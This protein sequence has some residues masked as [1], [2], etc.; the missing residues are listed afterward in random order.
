MA[1]F[2]EFKYIQLSRVFLFTSM[3]TFFRKYSRVL[4]GLLRFRKLRQ[5][6]GPQCV[7]F[8]SVC[9]PAVLFH[10]PATL[11]VDSTTRVSHVITCVVAADIPL[12]PNDSIGFSFCVYSFVMLRNYLCL[13]FSRSSWSVL[14]HCV[15]LGCVT[16]TSD[17]ILQ[18]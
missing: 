1:S 4:E 6:T 2:H 3:C 12:F 14:C 7:R 17:T 10:S 16:L 13:S 9:R 8:G 5:R 18:K 11:R 15:T